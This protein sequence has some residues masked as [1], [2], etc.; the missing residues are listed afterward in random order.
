MI[1]VEIRRY[2]ANFHIT[3]KCNMNCSYCYAGEHINLSMSDEVITSAIRFLIA[4]VNKK[5][6]NKLVVSFLGGEPLLELDKIFYIQEQLLSKV[7]NCVSVHFQLSTNGLLLTEEV[8]NKLVLKNTMVSLSLDGNPETLKIQRPLA[9][10][11]EK[12]YSHLIQRAITAVLKHNPFS[13]AFC[14][15]TP[16]SA[17][18]LFENITWIYN[19]GM[20]FINTTLDYSGA[21]TEKDFKI[22]EEQYLLLASWY[23]NKCA[24][25][26]HFYLSCFDERIQT[27]TKSPV[28]CNQKC[29]IGKFQVSISPEGIFYPCMQFVKPIHQADKKVQLGDLTHGINK[30]TTDELQEKI[31]S[32][33]PE[34]SECQ[35]KDRCST[36]CSCI[37]Y[38]S[39]RRV[40]KASPVACY[41]EKM[42][43]PL[44]DQMAKELFDVKDLLFL[45]KQYNPF[46]SFVGQALNQTQ[47]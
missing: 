30:T 23:K 4:E 38:A 7:S 28:G 35:I 37:N 45:H 27:R 46:Y 36:W 9:G 3:H 10:N 15:I 21:W 5:N 19:Q 33:K 16:S 18:N 14:V 34:C 29:S 41:H 13:N 40:E 8:M 25:I 42:L 12:D 24:D 22:L 47:R 1:K 17:K 32:E 31:I 39:T 11:P 6:I 2:T 26:D 20:R 44:V 43:I